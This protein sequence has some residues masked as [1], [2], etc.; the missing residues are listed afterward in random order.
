MRI[1]KV[2]AV[3]AAS[4]CFPCCMSLAAASCA[5]PSIEGM[6]FAIDTNKDGKLSHEEWR[7]QGL[8]ESSFAGLS[9]GKGYIL[10]DDWRADEPPPGIDKN[11]DCVIT[12]EEFRAFDKEM[13]AKMAAQPPPQSPDPGPR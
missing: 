9:K 6:I 8:P 1:G 10:P 13:R 11:G 3:I 5:K 12:L 2:T 7:A 4:F